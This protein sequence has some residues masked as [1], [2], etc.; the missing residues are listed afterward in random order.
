MAK[1]VIL[2][3]GGWGTAVAVM[4]AKYSKHEIV[5]WSAFEEEIATLKSDGENKKYL[6]GIKIPEE[7]TLISD[8][9]CT[10]DADIAVI[11]TPSFV[12]R[13]VCQK[14]RNFLPKD[15]VVVIISKG[16]EDGTLMRLSEVAFSELGDIKLAVMS[17]PSHA[18]EVAKG[19]PSANVVS[20]N[21][22]KISEYI[23][24][25]FMNDKFRLYTNNDIIGAELGGSLKN[26]I[27]LAAG[28]CDGI[29]YGDNTKAA[30]MTRG[31][32][33]MICLGSA[34]GSNAQTFSGL[35]GFGDLIVTCTSMHSR[36][37]RA[38][39]LIG[40][41]LS[42]DDAIKEVG[43]TVEGYKTCAAAHS[44]AQ[45]YKVNMPIINEAYAVLYENKNVSDAMLDLM[46]R[47]KKTEHECEYLP[48]S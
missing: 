27:A 34:M 48:F 14:L 9:S 36:N 31:I 11:A 37:R 21:D 1:I 6:P 19:I 29:G 35:T 39:I 46:R 38:G 33:E 42:A 4:M 41:G 32:A 13:S 30:L 26:V 8:I 16:L 24:D 45:K 44:L 22:V 5:L 47:S 40:Q 10:A 17:G 12:V 23:Q 18:E 3:S 28:I 7:I 20:S 25:T 15:S 2:G 43:M